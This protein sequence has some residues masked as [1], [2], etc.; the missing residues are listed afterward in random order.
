MSEHAHAEAHAPEGATTKI[1]M[2]VWI[3]LLALTAVEVFLAYIHTPLVVMLTVLMGLSVAKAYMIIAWFMHM[4]FEKRS[5]VITLFPM[6][7]FCILMLAVFIPDAQRSL[8]LR[9]K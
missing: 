3:A 1:F 7:I 8:E 2:M 5:L 9:P 6:L 4:K